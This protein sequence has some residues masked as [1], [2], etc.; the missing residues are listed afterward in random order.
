MNE[1]KMMEVNNGFKISN[2]L[3]ITELN[4]REYS[5]CN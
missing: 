3:G 4:S 1:M 5:F 2:I